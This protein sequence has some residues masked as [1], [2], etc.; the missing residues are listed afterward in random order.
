MKGDK[1]PIKLLDMQLMIVGKFMK[2]QPS[3]APKKKV[4]ELSKIKLVKMTTL[5]L[6]YSVKRTFATKHENTENV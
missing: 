6:L 5:T 4:I 2:G 3:D 1:A